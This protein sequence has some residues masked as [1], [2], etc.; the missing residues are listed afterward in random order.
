MAESHSSGVVSQG[1]ILFAV[2]TAATFCLRMMKESAKKVISAA[3]KRVR[4]ASVLPSA[5]EILCSIGGAHLL[6]GRSHEDNFPLSITHLPMLTDQLISREWTSAA[7][8]NAEVSSALSSGKSL[9]FLNGELLAELKPDL[10]LTQDLCS[11]CAIDLAEVRMIASE[12]NPQPAVLS[13]DPQTLEDVLADM[14]IVGEAVG[15]QKEAAKA[16]GI[17]ED[18]VR[19]VVAAADEILGEWKGIAAPQGKGRIKVAFIEWSDPIYV[20]GHWTPQLIYMAGGEHTLNPCGE[21]APNS[22]V[23]IGGAGKSFP[24]TT[25]SVIA[26]DPDLIIISPCGL[27]LEMSRREADRLMGQQWFLDLRAVRNKKLLVVDG[28]AMFNRPGPRLVDALEWLVSVFHD[29]GPN[30]VP[31]VARAVS[32]RPKDFPYFDYFEKIS[33]VDIEIVVPDIKKDEDLALIAI[34]EAHTGQP[35]IVFAVYE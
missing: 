1:F 34:E 10:I 20:G 7:A 30:P 17:L 15:L 4:V 6:V 26:S 35:R 18:R 13:L 33:A 27:N 32:L 21:G 28:D 2:H 16:K 3:V 23:Q 24:V 5:T 22:Y 11:V 9:Y 31:S 29:T 8:V 12:M 19:A 25:E 14:T